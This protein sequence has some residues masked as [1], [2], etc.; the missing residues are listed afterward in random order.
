MMQSK[1]KPDRAAKLRRTIFALCRE[2]GIGDEL[3][4]ELQFSVT[5]KESLT[6]CTA[7]EMRAVIER[8]AGQSVWTPHGML[9]KLAA[10]VENG[11]PRLRAFCWKRFAREPEELDD[12]RTR[13]GIAFL[14]DG[15]KLVYKEA[16]ER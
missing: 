15:R 7:A 6:E 10:E 2:R 16:G 3:R 13:L 1:A 9:E 8:L 11:R 5:G 14:G 4:H 12:N